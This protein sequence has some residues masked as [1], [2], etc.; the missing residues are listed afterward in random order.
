MSMGD[1][2]CGTPTEAPFVARWNSYPDPVDPLLS[3]TGTI[4]SNDVTPSPSNDGLVPVGSARYGTFLGCIPADHLDEMCQLAND[5]PGAGNPFD[6]HLF[7]RQL[8]DWLV[9]RG[10]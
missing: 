6:C 1:D 10:Y 4:L 8:A 7:Y 9:A 2:A 5:S 3:A